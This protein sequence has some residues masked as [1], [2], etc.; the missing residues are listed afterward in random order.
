MSVSNLKAQ[1][2]T[3]DIISGTYCLVYLVYSYNYVKGEMCNMFEGTDSK[4]T[5]ELRFHSTHHPYNS[6]ITFSAVQ[7]SLRILHLPGNKLSQ[8]LQ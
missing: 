1:I 6:L 7:L 3:Q 4:E 5:P 2:I 8:F